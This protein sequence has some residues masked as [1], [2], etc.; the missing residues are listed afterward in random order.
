VKRTEGHLRECLEDAAARFLPLP[1][2]TMAPKVRAGALV[3]VLSPAGTALELV[4]EGCTIAHFDAGAG[5]SRVRVR[6]RVGVR[7]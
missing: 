6:V 4:L 1:A 5:R 2:E 7:V 3:L